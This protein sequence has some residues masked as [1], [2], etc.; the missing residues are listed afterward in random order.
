MRPQA[1]YIPCSGH[2]NF[3][4]Q[5]HFWLKADIARW[6]TRARQGLFYLLGVP[7][8]ILPKRIGLQDLLERHL[9]DIN[10]DLLI[11]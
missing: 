1:K 4:F 6:L 5:E 10:K 2:G 3:I 7:L 8:A 9:I 11:Q